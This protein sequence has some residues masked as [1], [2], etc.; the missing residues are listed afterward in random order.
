MTNENNQNTKKGRRKKDGSANTQ[1]EGESANEQFGGIY[2]ISH[3][4]IRACEYQQQMIS[5]PKLKTNTKQNNIQG[6]ILCKITTN[7]KPEIVTSKTSS[8]TGA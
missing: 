1:R 5:T 7:T 6:N 2:Q 8:E 4:N 3:P